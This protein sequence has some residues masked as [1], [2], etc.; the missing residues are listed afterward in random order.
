MQ[1]KGQKARE[2]ALFKLQGLQ[3]QGLCR[4]EEG[5]GAEGWSSQR[6]VVFVRRM[7]CSN[8]RQFTSKSGKHYV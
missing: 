5:A 6:P 8:L 3:N 7:H 2:D 1:M 4:L